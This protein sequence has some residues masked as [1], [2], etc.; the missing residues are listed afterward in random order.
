MFVQSTDLITFC[1]FLSSLLVD[2]GFSIH[3]ANGTCWEH[4]LFR[5]RMRECTGVIK[6]TCRYMKT[7]LLLGD[8][9]FTL[10]LPLKIHIRHSYDKH[11]GIH[12]QLIDQAPAGYSN[13]NSNNRKQKARGGRWE[14]AKG[15][16]LCHIMHSRWR[17]IS[18][19]FFSFPF[20]S[21]P[22]SFLFSPLQPSLRYEEALTEERGP[23]R[24]L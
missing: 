19:F 20:P 1:Q 12:L 23:S 10:N 5:L 18:S 3:T 9:L 15:G 6:F 24:Y 22:A 11:R 17:R 16:I 4:I 2:F 21:S 7:N 8:E 14:E 13:K